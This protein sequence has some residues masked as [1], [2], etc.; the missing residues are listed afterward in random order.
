MILDIIITKTYFK[1]DNIV[2]L[3][4]VEILIKFL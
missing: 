2:I 1:Y 4:N 3:D